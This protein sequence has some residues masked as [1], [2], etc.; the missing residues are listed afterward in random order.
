MYIKLQ[1]VI[2]KK[3]IIDTRIT[4]V[5]PDNEL[6][7]VKA[8]KILSFDEFLLLIK[9]FFRSVI[10]GYNLVHHLPRRHSVLRSSI[11]YFLRLY[12]FW[13]NYTTNANSRSAVLRSSHG[14]LA[15]VLILTVFIGLNT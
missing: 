12:L 7:K 6:N 14:S 10:F 4:A 9:L 11:K 3:K 13:R 2:L 5:N 1:L 8:R 15:F